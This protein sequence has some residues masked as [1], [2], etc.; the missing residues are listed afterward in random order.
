MPETLMFE[1]DLWNQCNLTNKLM[2][3]LGHDLAQ[4]GAVAAV[5]I[6]DEGWGAGG[7]HLQIAVV[8]GGREIERCVDDTFRLV[9]WVARARSIRIGL[10]VMAGHRIADAPAEILNDLGLN[11]ELSILSTVLR[12]FK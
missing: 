8:T 4:Q 12:R 10:S 7:I 11:T 6:A 1:I 9:D 5:W 3:D 2:E